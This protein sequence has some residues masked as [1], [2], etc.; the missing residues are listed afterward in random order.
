M[1]CPVCQVELR[2]T[3]S[4]NLIEMDGDK[5]RLFVEMDLTCIN[6]QCQNYEKVVETSRSEQPVG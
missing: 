2:I 5:P 1:K 6:K 4:R 3:R